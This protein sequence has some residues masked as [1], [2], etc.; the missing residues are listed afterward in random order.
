MTFAGMWS[1]RG[2]ARHDPPADDP[3]IPDREARA[4]LT[5]IPWVGGV[6]IQ[7]CSMVLTARTKRRSIAG[8]DPC[9]E[10]ELVF[11]GV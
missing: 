3:A 10:A 1:G 11:P 9:P 7:P 2:A 6:E 8:R 5:E 4:L